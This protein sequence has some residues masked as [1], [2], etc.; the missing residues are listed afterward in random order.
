MVLEPKEVYG[1]FPITM[2]FPIKINSF[3]HSSFYNIFLWLSKYNCV[4]T[5]YCIPHI[6]YV[7]RGYKFRKY[8]FI[9]SFQ[10]GFTSLKL[11]Y[12]A[13]YVIFIVTFGLVYTIY[14]LWLILRYC[15]TYN[16]ITKYPFPKS[17][18]F[19]TCCR[20]LYIQN[21]SVEL[22]LKSVYLQQVC[23]DMSYWY[24]C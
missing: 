6:Q 20:L 17:H 3:T 23:F 10:C 13:Q 8:E 5:M 7:F 11:G 15:N 21:M 18:I 16:L 14:V 1:D 9:G 24:L 2:G 12:L 22:G 4:H 19:S